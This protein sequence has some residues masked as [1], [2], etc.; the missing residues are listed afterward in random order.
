M[1][2]RAKRDDQ[3]RMELAAIHTGKR[4]L[5]LDDAAYRGLLG[6][7]TGKSSAADLTGTERARVLDRMRE[8]GFGRAGKARPAPRERKPATQLDKARALWGE[9]AQLGPVELRVLRD[10]SE[11]AFYA[12]VQRQTGKSRPEW[13]TPQELNAVIEGLKA[14]LGRARRQVARDGEG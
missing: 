9:L 6:Q 1:R 14:W 13:C 7:V 10:S 3:R 8:L 11:A 5:G 4:A 12:F 2:A